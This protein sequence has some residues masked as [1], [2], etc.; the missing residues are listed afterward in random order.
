MSPMNAWLILRGLRTLDI[1]LKKSDETGRK[2][3]EFLAG[4]PAVEKVY[5]PFH[6]SHPQYEIARKQMKG[7][8][9]LMSFTLKT[10]DISKIEAFCNGLKYF[11]LACS[12]GSYESLCFPAAALVS[13]SNYHSSPF[14]PNMFRIYC[15]LEEAD[16]LIEDIRHSLFLSGI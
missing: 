6:A 10:D 8:G 16:L 7:A 4:H 5:Y 11:L 3:A 2:M 9:G 14:P 1:R 12:W 15:G 13:S